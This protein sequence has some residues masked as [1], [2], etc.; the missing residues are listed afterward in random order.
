[1]PFGVEEFEVENAADEAQEITLVVPRP[2]LVNLQEKELKPTDQD[3][4]Y[5]CSAPVHGHAH[6][7]FR[8]ANIRGVVMGSTESPNRMALAVADSP[9][10]KVDIQPYFC[11]NRYSQ[12]LL[13][14]ADGSFFEKTGSSPPKRL[15]SGRQPD[16]H[17]GVESVEKN[18][19]GRCPGLPGAV[20]I[21]GAKFERKYVKSF[22]DKETRTIDMA[23]LA[24][25]RYP[26]WWDRTGEISEEDIRLHP[27]QPRI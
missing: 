9:G 13:L 16:V 18:R 4:I 27:G 26:R 21:D 17:R 24:L 7:E 3:S 10:V 2:S 20:F 6:K 1:M 12:D 11:L 14:N 25:D 19:G 8:S 5:I 15:W 23:K 22:T